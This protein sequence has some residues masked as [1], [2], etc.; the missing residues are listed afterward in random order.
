MP[1]YRVYV[2]YDREGDDNRDEVSDPFEAPD[3]QTAK[4]WT[5]EA[6]LHREEYLDQD[7]K[8]KPS[9]DLPHPCPVYGHISVGRDATESSDFVKE[10]HV[11]EDTGSLPVKELYDKAD[12]NLKVEQRMLAESRERQDYERLKA[13]YG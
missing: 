6:L 5:M 8:W 9:E 2:Q 10:V 12:D 4:L 1:Q 7:G 3:L 11:F 13:K